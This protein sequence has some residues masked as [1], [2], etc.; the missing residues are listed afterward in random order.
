MQEQLEMILSTVFGV[1]QTFKREKTSKCWR[2]QRDFFKVPHIIWQLITPILGLLWLLRGTLN[3]FRALP[4]IKTLSQQGGI[5]RKDLFQLMMNANKDSTDEKVGRLTMTKL[6]PNQFFFIGWLRYWTCNMLSFIEYYLGMN[7]EMQ[8]K[9]RRNIKEA[10]EANADEALYD[11][12]KSIEYLDC[13][14]KES[15]PIPL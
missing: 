2:T 13:V 14:I 8:E 6:W 15:R 11:V 10:M 4:V 7:P 3:H 1:G 9:L 5:V 12:A